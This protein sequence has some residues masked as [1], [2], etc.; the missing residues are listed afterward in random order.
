MVIILKLTTWLLPAALTILLVGC[1]E[2]TT[3]V[4]KELG[5]K[6]EFTKE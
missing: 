5:E 2:E 6:N 4:Q 1:N 3:E